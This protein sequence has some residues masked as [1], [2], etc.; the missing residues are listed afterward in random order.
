MKKVLLITMM[1]TSCMLV[2]AQN[3]LLMYIDDI[4]P[5]QVLEFCIPDYDRQYLSSV[6]TNSYIDS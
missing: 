4:E 3:Y 1:L 2:K 5:D 6:R